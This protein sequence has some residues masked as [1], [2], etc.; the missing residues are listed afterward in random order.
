MEVHFKPET[1]SRLREL[2][3]ESGRATDDLAEDAMA[4]YLAEL[5]QVREML[6]GRY[7][8]IKSGRVKPID[9]EEFFEQLRQ[10]EDDLLKRRSSQ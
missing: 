5:S 7:D 9:G 10:R 1:E 6:D 4:A 8:E 3:S 2:A